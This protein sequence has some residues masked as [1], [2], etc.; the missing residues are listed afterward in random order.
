[1]AAGE[2]TGRGG[3]PSLIGKYNIANRITLSNKMT[4]SCLVHKH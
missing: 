3:R 2:G 1:M 4:S